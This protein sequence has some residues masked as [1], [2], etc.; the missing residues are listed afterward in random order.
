MD[1]INDDFVRLL[2][3]YLKTEEAKKF[4]LEHEKVVE[5]AHVALSSK[6]ESFSEYEEQILT[7]LSQS[8]TLYIKQSSH[9]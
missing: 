5:S 8:S 2:E 7:E 1:K 6:I 4:I 3:S 9:K